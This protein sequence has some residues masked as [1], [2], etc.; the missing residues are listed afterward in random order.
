MDPNLP[1]TSDVLLSLLRWTLGL[2]AGT[3]AGLCIAVLERG[4]I[5][6][7]TAWSATQFLA[8]LWTGVLDFLRALPI[9]ALIPVVQMIGINESF[10][11][12]LIAWAVMFPVWL[13]VRQALVRNII[14]TEIS[15]H[16]SGLSGVE[17]FR[18]YSLPKAIGG[19]LR[20]VE[21]SIG[22]AWLSVVAAEWIGTYTR[23]FWSGGLGYRVQQAHDANS[24]PG[25]IGCLVCFGLLGLATAWVW[26]KATQNGKS[27]VR[28]LNLTS[29][30]AN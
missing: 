28:G 1:S 3:F 8:R 6:L 18:V 12:A 21:I 22:I 7:T 26:R 25:M 13:S 29:T 30:D 20:G 15:L 9:V 16:A 4:L 27:P 23:G 2:I 24:W 19:L 14:D 17:V 10:K 11:I 5:R